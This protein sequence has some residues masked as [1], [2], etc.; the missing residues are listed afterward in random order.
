MND[1]SVKFIVFLADEKKED[2][3][4]DIR[5]IK[6]HLDKRIKSTKSRIYAIKQQNVTPDVLKTLDAELAQD[7]KLKTDLDQNYRSLI[8][9]R[10]ELVK[11][12]EK[13]NVHSSIVEQ[14]L[15]WK[16]N[17]A[18]FNHT[19]GNVVLEDE[20]VNEE[21]QIQIKDLTEKNK[22]LKSEVGT[23]Q[24]QCYE[25]D[26]KSQEAKDSIQ[27]VEEKIL[28]ER[29]SH[30]VEI[31]ALKSLIDRQNK[32]IKQLGGE[33]L[34]RSPSPHKSDTKLSDDEKGKI[35]NN[36]SASENQK[37]LKSIPMVES[38]TFGIKK[39]EGTEVS[40]KTKEP[41]AEH[42][43]KDSYDESAKSNEIIVPNDKQFTNLKT[44]QV[45][46]IHVENSEDLRKS[47][48]ENSDVLTPSSIKV[49]TGVQTMEEQLEGSVETTLDEK[50]LTSSD[51]GLSVKSE[52]FE[53]NQHLSSDAEDYNSDE[54]I[55]NCKRTLEDRHDPTLKYDREEK[56]ESPKERNLSKECP[57]S[58]S[59]SQ[60]STHFSAGSKDAKDNITSENIIKGLISSSHSETNGKIEIPECV[61]EDFQESF[62][63]MIQ[64][65]SKDE[66][67]TTLETTEDDIHVYEGTTKE[68]M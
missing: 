29:L 53:N 38:L 21:I 3:K 67:I 43:N 4:A 54:D 37:P 22:A 19:Y 42:E 63:D 62:A 58:S 34:G 66:C 8:D 47:K 52:F 13:R 12:L 36:E 32:L 11:D 65:V 17:V 14:I 9:K 23:L 28:E 26:K 55:S 18:D 45:A 16:E 39:Q 59:E 27:K 64:L 5:D 2:V 41:E 68:I 30:E 56:I 61:K 35:E 60:A 48:L 49:S 25:S 46:L 15:Q 31:N 10:N 24:I 44:D 57:E 33:S 50:E 6:K 20:Q 1:I 51:L 7:L 40:F